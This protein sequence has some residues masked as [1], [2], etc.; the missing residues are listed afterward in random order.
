[1]LLLII[2]LAAEI[3]EKSP[4][5]PDDLPSWQSYL[6]SPCV[7]LMEWGRYVVQPIFCDTAR[8]DKVQRLATVSS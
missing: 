1:M 8:L 5:P 3:A 2:Q 7:E 4:A 6:L